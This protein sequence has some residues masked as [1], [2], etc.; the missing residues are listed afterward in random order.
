[1]HLSRLDQYP[2]LFTSWVFRLLPGEC[3]K[4]PDASCGHIFAP[5]PLSHV[6]WCRGK[7]DDEPLPT[8]WQKHWLSDLYLNIVCCCSASLC[9]K[10]TVFN[11]WLAVCQALYLPTSPD[12]L[13]SCPRACKV[14]PSNHLILRHSPSLTPQSF[15]SISIFLPELSIFTSGTKSLIFQ[16]QPFPWIFRSWILL[17]LIIDFPCH[18]SDSQVYSPPQFKS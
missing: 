6:H 3:H 17:G 10:L 4:P 8:R 14:M 9:Q 13:N 16:H 2:M 1:M 11:Q 7:H 18:P 15:P 12:L 5:E